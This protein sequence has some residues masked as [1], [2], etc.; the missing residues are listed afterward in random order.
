[1]ALTAIYAK[2]ALIGEELQALSG[3][4]IL[5]K[6]E[7]IEE[8][9]TRKEFEES[10]REAEIIDLSDKIILPGLIECHSHMALDARVPGHL[11]VIDQ[12]ECEHT[13]ITLKGLEDELM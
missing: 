12:S 3:A 6:G 7:K 11:G 5:V 2:Q 13:V 1:M 10:G 8:I 9:T 4:C